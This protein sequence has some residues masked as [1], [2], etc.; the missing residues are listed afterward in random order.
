MNI[1]HRSGSPGDGLSTRRPDVVEEAGHIVHQFVDGFAVMVACD[2]GVK[3][4]PEPLDL[5]MLWAVRR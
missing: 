3:I 4:A 5:V 2:L 1:V